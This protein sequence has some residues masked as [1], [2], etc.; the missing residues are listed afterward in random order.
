[1]EYNAQ[2]LRIREKTLPLMIGVTLLIALFCANLATAA[3]ISANTDPEAIADLRIA[4]GQN[5]IAEAWLIAPVTRYKHFVQ[6]SNYEPGGVRLKMADGRVLTLMLDAAYVFEDRQPRLADLDGDGKD[7][8]ILVLTALDQG[9]SL[10][11]YAVEGDAITLK[12]KT[13]FV[14]QPY[15]WLNPAGIADFDGDGQLDVALVAMPHLVKRLEFWTLGPKGFQ[16]IGAVDDVSNHNNG[17]PFT[18]MAAVADIDHDGI[19]DLAIPDG[20]RRFIRVISFA[21]GKVRDIARLPL[22]FAANG[23]FSLRQQAE[24]YVLTVPM[25]GGEIAELKL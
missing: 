14:G 21:K 5:D 13:P 2:G 11:A 23:T 3:G 9:A 18:G 6:G 25:T 17:S 1:M 15:R 24:G 8:I 10:A 22:P 20:S 4:Q 16:K 19:A 7:E 12:A